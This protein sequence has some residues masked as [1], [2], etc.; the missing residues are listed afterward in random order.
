MT[1]TLSLLF[2]LLLL[3]KFG[4]SFM[5]DAVD[6]NIVNGGIPKQND[7]GI[8]SNCR[9]VCVSMEAKYISQKYIKYSVENVGAALH[10]V[11]N[12]GV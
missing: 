10:P 6:L 8:M 7:K 5:L 11:H 4:K 12:S 9:Y 3:C 2:H 1:F